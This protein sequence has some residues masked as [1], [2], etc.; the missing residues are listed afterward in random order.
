M[1]LS[2]LPAELRIKIQSNFNSIYDFINYCDTE[3]KNKLF[4]IEEYKKILKKKGYLSIPSD[5]KIEEVFSYLKKNRNNIGDSAA[6]FVFFGGKL[7]RNDTMEIFNKYI[8]VYFKDFIIRDDYRYN[9]LFKGENYR[10]TLLQFKIYTNI[11]IDL[12]ILPKSFLDEELKRFRQILALIDSYIRET[13][14]YSLLNDQRHS[15]L[16][17]IIFT[18]LHRIEVHKNKSRISPYIVD[19]LVAAGLVGLLGFKHRNIIKRIIIRPIKKAIVK[20]LKSK[21]E[22]KN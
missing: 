4:C 10:K 17:P 20:K 18:Y 5:K 2:F 22:K 12:S 15:P 6:A 3:K 16:R 8:M 11:N 19:G 14:P 7:D 13:G 21:K 1:S 9:E